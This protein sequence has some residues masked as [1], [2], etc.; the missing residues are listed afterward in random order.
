[1]KVRN[2]VEHFL[3]KEITK[4]LCSTIQ[5]VAT[6]RDIF[7]STS[8][9]FVKKNYYTAFVNEDKIYG[10]FIVV[11]VRRIINKTFFNINEVISKSPY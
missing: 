6:E 10:K 2:F 1:M 5:S 11:W 9:S 3:G 8:L 7:G 4:W